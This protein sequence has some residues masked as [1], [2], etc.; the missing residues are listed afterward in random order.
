MNNCR[1]CQEILWMELYGELSPMERSE[2]KRHLEVCDA[3]RREKAGTGRMLERIQVSMP[4]PAIPPDGAERVVQ[5]LRHGRRPAKRQRPEGMIGQKWALAGA[6]CLILIAAAALSILRF[7]PFDAPDPS[8]GNP[9]KAAAILNE[10]E[11][12]VIQH[13]DL[14]QEMDA[15]QKLVQRIDRSETDVLPIKDA[16]DEL[17]SDADDDALV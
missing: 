13:L 2:W 4:A 17:R 11:V 3:C 6:L 7:A 8:V 5:R 14:L 16:T 1:N 15:L 10:E 12:E 9:L